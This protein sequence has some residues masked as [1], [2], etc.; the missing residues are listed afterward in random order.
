MI[1]LKVVLLVYLL[2]GAVLWYV[3]IKI[4]FDNGQG[5]KKYL[6]EIDAPAGAYYFCPVIFTVIWP[7]F[8]KK[9]GDQDEER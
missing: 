6:E 8:I 4:N 7:M 2:V 5:Y 1:V 3:G 9:K